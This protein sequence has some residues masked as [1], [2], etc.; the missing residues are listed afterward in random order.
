MEHSFSFTPSLKKPVLLFRVAA[1][2]NCHKLS[3]LEQHRLIFLEFL[4]SEFQNV[5][6]WA[7]IDMLQSCIPSGRSGES[8]KYQWLLDIS[9]FQRLLAFFGLWSLLHPRN[10]QRSIFI[11]LSDSLASDPISTSSVFLTLLPS[12]FEGPCDYIGPTWII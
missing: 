7:K 8:L 1:L 9:S 5:S 3:S 2:T 11:S 4:S 12:S 6:H 10:Q